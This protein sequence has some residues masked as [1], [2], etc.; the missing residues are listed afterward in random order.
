[1]IERGQSEAIQLVRDT[2]STG[3][4]TVPPMVYVDEDGLEEQFLT[5][6]EATQE[7]AD[8][9]TNRVTTPV[10]VTDTAPLDPIYTQRSQQE[11][12][13]DL[14]PSR[15]PR[16]NSLLNVMEQFLDENYEDVLRTS[17]MQTDFSVIT[18]NSAPCQVKSPLRWIVPDG[19]N[20]RLEEITD[21]KKADG[22]PGG[23]SSGSMVIILP[24]IEPYFG[25][26][27]FLV[28]IETGELFTLIQQQWRRTGLS[29]AE[30][31]FVITQLMEKVERM[32]RIMQTEFEAE[33]QTPVVL[34]QR[35]P[36]HFEVPPPLPVMDEPEVYV[37]HQDVM[38]TNMRKNY[39]RDR[40]RA[41]LI[42]ISEYAET[43]KMLSE[44]KYRQEDLLVRLRAIFGTVDRVRSQI[45]Q[46]LQHDNAHRR[47]RDMRFL[48][49]PIRFPRPESM[50]QSDVTVWT[51]WI[52]EETTTVMNQL[53]E[54]LEARGDPDD[55]F[56]GS[57]NGI[58]QPLPTSLSLPPPV[59]TPNN[60]KVSE[61]REHSQN[62]PKKKRETRGRTNTSIE[63]RQ[64]E[65]KTQTHAL[66]RQSREHSRNS[67]NPT[68]EVAS[69]SRQN[70]QL[71]QL[72]YE[73]AIPG[74][75]DN[76]ITF[77]PLPT[78]AQGRGQEY[79]QQEPKEQR[80]H[81]RRAQNG[82][83]KLNQKQFN[84]SRNQ[85][86]SHISPVE[87]VNGFNIEEPSVSYLQLPMGR[88]T[89]QRVCSKCGKPGHWKKYCQSTTWCRFC[90][91]GTHSTRACRRYTNFVKDNP[92]AS[93]RRTTPEHPIK[94]QQGFPQPPTQRFQAPAIPL[95]EGGNQ[96]VRQPRMQQN[97]QDVRTDPRF[98]HPP[99]HYSQIPLHRQVPPVEVNEL[100][101][102]IQQG[103]IQQPRERA[104]VNRES[105][106]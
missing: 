106:P 59:Q 66:Q 8:V 67:R 17:N 30:Q 36:G 61:S 52:H 4:T 9:T 76:L 70:I 99:P 77:T 51:N 94:S 80:N 91:S 68:D 7:I 11:E 98:R 47:R 19:T 5:E 15:G 74:V 87:Q 58:Y 24:R 29:C 53:D 27:F 73:E 12:E 46:A 14:Q 21:R 93:S 63:A 71:Q 3:S 81:Q 102:T 34:L 42:Y 83:W 96:R 44:D 41:A 103:V 32:G 31:P 64:A 89:D 22:T 65:L 48:L 105:R 90:T 6:D 72:Q 95:T 57:A 25:T 82:T 79:P 100:G 40:M 18:H 50:N 45:D 2:I 75:E 54:E 49:L 38:D 39:V 55:L 26:Q 101:P 37:T 23:G 92:I 28:D 69:P 35:N 13:L 16:S 86:I 20:R 97:S 1:M 78:N 56:N 33:Q 104:E 88:S 60:R 84:H 62:S 85:E 43:Q 10:E